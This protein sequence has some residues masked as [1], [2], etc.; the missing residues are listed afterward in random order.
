MMEFVVELL[1]LRPISSFMILYEEI[2]KLIL[3][4]RSI[5]DEISSVIKWIA[6]ANQRISFETNPWNN[7]MKNFE[8]FV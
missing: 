3:R 4:N 1:N 6:V 7:W 5:N 2:V 8:C